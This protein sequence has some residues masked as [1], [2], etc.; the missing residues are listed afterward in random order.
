MTKP[1]RKDVLA[2]IPQAQNYQAAETAMP[3]IA[4]EPIAT[5]ALKLTALPKNG[6]SF[7]EIVAFAYSFDG[8]A[9]YGMEAC[10]ELAN[11]ALSAYYHEAVLPDDM[12]E[13]RACLFFEARR[14][15]LYGTMPDTKANIYIVALIDQLKKK[16]E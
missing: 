7:P 3:E 1:L 5:E 16:L 4:V 12:T 8:Y 9:Y 15:M 10:A 6:A 11:K 2:S 13:I 14:W